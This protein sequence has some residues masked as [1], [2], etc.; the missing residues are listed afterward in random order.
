MDGN[1]CFR[2]EMELCSSFPTCILIR[3]GS[4][5]NR[6]TQRTCLLRAVYSPTCRCASGTIATSS[7]VINRTFLKV[8]FFF[9]ARWKITRSQLT[10]AFSL[11]KIKPYFPLIAEVCEELK[12]CIE[13][14]SKLV[15]HAGIR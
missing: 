1:N 14:S 8:C 11:G 4:T 7:T 10:P 6:T 15:S 12:R 3:T 5:C 2:F 9:P 13:N